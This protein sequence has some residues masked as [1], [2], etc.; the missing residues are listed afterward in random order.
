[1][2][3]KR[4][5]L[6]SADLLIFLCLMGISLFGCAAIEKPGSQPAPPSGGAIPE[7]K[8]PVL[9]SDGEKQQPNLKIE[10]IKLQ[11]KEYEADREFR[12]ALQAW[13]RILALDPNHPEARRMVSQLENG[14]KTAV[15]EHLQLGAAD[16]R[17]GNFERAKKELLM[18]LF[19]DS[20]QKEALSYLR[21]ISSL[22]T[23]PHLV[24][25]PK[26][27][28]VVKEPP[29][30]TPVKADGEFV[31]HTIQQ[32]E[33]LS[34]VAE[35]Y[36]GDKMKYQVL[37][38]FNS[39][40]DA[41]KVR[42]GQTIK[43][44]IQKG[45]ES[46]A[47]PPE[48]SVVAAQEESKEPKK[49]PSKRD[50]KGTVLTV[51][52]LEQRVMQGKKF[53]QENKFAEAAVEFQEIVLAHPEHK[54]AADYMT[55]SQAIT[56]SLQKGA[57]LYDAKEYESAYDE[58][59]RVLSVKPDVVP[60]KDRIEHLIPLLVAKARYLLHEEQSPCETIALAKK[61]LQGGPNHS[62]A[63]RL[64]EEA[65]ELERGLELQCS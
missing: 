53:Y 28:P 55:K 45:T 10:E 30:G 9:R 42:A 38:D 51:V 48:K 7:Q 63:K 26:S 60:A 58:F 46:P 31:L 19:L 16:F 57:S 8:R 20:T 54:E 6:R 41:T 56:A 61:I 40:S 64:L 62:E 43:V 49:G 52:S 14:L 23:A 50:L 65:I 34:I 21:Q 11:I 33:S 24:R 17:E 37:A 15:E 35:R 44:P 1:M 12:K 32:G 27:R 59:H 4:M 36:Y 39:I 25:A 47:K 2:T 13:K 3:M 22:E 18:V 5:M 29:E